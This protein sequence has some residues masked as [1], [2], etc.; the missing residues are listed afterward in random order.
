MIIIC[1]KY[2]WL[3]IKIYFK[4][5]ITSFQIHCSKK[6]K[7]HIFILDGVWVCFWCCGFPEAIFNRVSPRVRAIRIDDWF[8]D[9]HTWI[10]PFYYLWFILPTTVS[11]STYCL[12]KQRFTTHSYT[13][14]HTHVHCIIF[15]M[16]H[17]YSWQLDELPPPRNK[18]N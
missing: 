10:N 6:I 1:N 14:T 7:N 8:N 17:L 13:R 11:L 2:T 4:N 18:M 9:C 12:Q 16:N 15:R 5:E 3:I